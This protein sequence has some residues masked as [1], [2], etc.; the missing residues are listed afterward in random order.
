[1]VGLSSMIVI[2]YTLLGVGKFFHESGF[3]GRIGGMTANLTGF[4]IAG[5]VAVAAF[6][7]ENSSI[8][9]TISTGK[10]SPEKKM[11]KIAGF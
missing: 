1:M 10:I 6:V 11:L 3:L 9:E 7:I 8:D 5:L 4:Y 2:P